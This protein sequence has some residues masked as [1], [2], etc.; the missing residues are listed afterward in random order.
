MT[1]SDRLYTKAAFHEFIQRPEN[2]H[3]R[4]ELIH[5]EPVAAAPGKATD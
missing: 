4:Y 3:K 5:G 2:R 1:V